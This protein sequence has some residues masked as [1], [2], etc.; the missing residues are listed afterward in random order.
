MIDKFGRKTSLLLVSAP[1]AVGWLLTAVARSIPLLYFGRFLVGI[2]V[3]IS[4][5]AVPV[6]IF[7]FYYFQDVWPAASFLLVQVLG[8]LIGKHN[9]FF[10]YILI[11]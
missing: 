9:R 8:I 5:I 6:S 4:S 1:Y 3:G 7:D 11:L 10:K 2:A